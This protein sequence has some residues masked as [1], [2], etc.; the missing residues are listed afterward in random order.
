MSEFKIQALKEL[1]EQQTRFAP[2]VRRQA[3]VA[4][5]QELLSEIDAGKTYPY[6]Y[7]CFR[8]TDYRSATNADLLINGE[9]LRHDLAQFIRRAGTVGPGAAGRPDRRA[10]A[11]PRRSEQ[12]V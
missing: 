12:A 7:V 11:H 5:A 10:D 3:Q 4:N 8:L 2:A 9:D 1:T 6:Q